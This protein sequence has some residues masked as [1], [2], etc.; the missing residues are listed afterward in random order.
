MSTQCPNSGS[1]AYVVHGFQDPK[2]NW[3][4][5]LC[6]QFLQQ[7]GGCCIY[8]DWGYY[9]LNI[10][11]YG[12]TMVTLNGV[13]DSFLRRLIDLSA[14][15]F[16]PASWILYGHS[17]G[18]RLVIKTGVNFNNITSLVIANVDVCDQ[19]GPGFVIDDI[20]ETI[21]ARNAGQNVQ[22]IHTSA[23]FGTVSEFNL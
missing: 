1:I 11:Y 23:S 18:G 6:Q 4:A 17:L 8:M 3:G 22:C 15:G 12:I 2:S 13:A 5:R 20:E 14:D 21:N 7:R 10:N 19:A 16:N 9:A